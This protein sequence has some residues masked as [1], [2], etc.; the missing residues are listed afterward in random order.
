M[1]GTKR[2]SVMV[3]MKSCES[4]TKAAKNVLAKQLGED[5]MVIERNIT[6]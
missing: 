4:V 3:F 5:K 2:G 1:R 6:K